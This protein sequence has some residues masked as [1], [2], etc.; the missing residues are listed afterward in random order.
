MRRSNRWIGAGR[1]TLT[2]VLL[3]L[4]LLLGAVERDTWSSDQ[5]KL[6]KALDLMTVDLIKKYH[7]VLTTDEMD[8]RGAGTPGGLKA[9]EFIANCFK[10]AKLKPVG[11]GGGGEGEGYFQPFTMKGKECRNC[12]GLLEGSD[13]KLKDE[14]IVVGGHHDHAG[15]KANPGGGQNG[16]TKGND[17][18]WNGADDNGSGSSMVVTLANVFALSGLKTKRSILF[19][20]FDAEEHGLV[21]SKNYAKS[22]LFDIK[23]HVAMI[24]LDMIGRNPDRPVDHWGTSTFEGD[25]VKDLVKKASEKAGLNISIHK[26]LGQYWMRSDQGSFYA[27]DIP[28]M[29]FFTGEHA[30]YHKITDHADK[31]AYDRMAQ[32]GKTV[33]AILGELGTMDQV[34]KVVK[35][36]K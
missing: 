31:I 3:V 5:E 1:V 22:P 14:I 13:D 23:K 35:K 21:G 32:I 10:E 6:E 20:T 36:K 9:T 16:G 24:N 26:D 29:F 17:T 7:S 8:G 30:D 33:I 12:V 15:S 19:I 27:K 4:P 28:A 2:G 25:T 18:I 34:P 11:K